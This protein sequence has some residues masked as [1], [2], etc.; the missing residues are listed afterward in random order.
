MNILIFGLGALGTVYACLL[1]EAGHRVTVV[2]R[3]AVKS[4]IKDQG[5]RVTGIWGNHESRPDQVVTGYDE[6]VGEK[7]D[8]AVLTVKSFDTAEVALE[9]SKVLHKD[10][11]ILLAQNGCGNYEAAAG[12]L[13]REKVILGRV[14]F[15]SVTKATGEAQVTAIADDVVIGSPEGLIDS[16]TVENF[17]RVFSQAGIPTRTSDEVMK[18]VWAKI[19]YNSSLN[20]L[21]ALFEVSYG[22]LAE[23]IYTREM[24][25]RVVKEIFGLLAAMGRETLWTDADT[26]LKEFYEVV[27]PRTA[28]HHASMLQ[29]IRRGKKTEIDALNGAVVQLGKEFDTATPV[30]EMLTLMVKA[31]EQFLLRS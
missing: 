9:L 11:Y 22:Q 18:Y 19:I 30:N 2:A 21:G 8:I 17:A 29:D 15:G 16:A 20:A 26:Y 27:I 3:E 23:N 6:L 7:F 1:K 13:P 14:I 4:T 10:T 12:H 24:I 28:A 25:D 5:V 31:R